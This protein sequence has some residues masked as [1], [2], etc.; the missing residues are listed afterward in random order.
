MLKKLTMYNEC[1]VAINPETIFHFEDKKTE[2]EIVRQ[3]ETEKENEAGNEGI[4]YYGCSVHTN[5]TGFSVPCTK[6][7]YSLER[8]KQKIMS[9]I[10][11]EVAF[12]SPKAQKDL[13]DKLNSVS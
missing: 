8:A 3:V 7:G 2:I 11:Q 1:D 4:S 6:N 13:I 5:N 10:D 9:F 12:S